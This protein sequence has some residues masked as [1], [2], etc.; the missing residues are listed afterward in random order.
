ME[1]RSENC[2]NRGGDLSGRVDGLWWYKDLG[3]HIH[4]EFSMAVI[5]ANNVLE[6]QSQIES[7]PMSSME[8]GPRGTFVGIYDGHAGPEASRFINN[9]LFENIKS[10]LL[11]LSILFFACLNS[12]LQYVVFFSIIHLGFNSVLCLDSFGLLVDVTFFYRGMCWTFLYIK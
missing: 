5:Q 8:A 2:S 11:C 7:G 1:S 10:M 12:I 6:D 9:H 3:H 4:G